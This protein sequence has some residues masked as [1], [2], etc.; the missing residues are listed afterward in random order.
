MSFVI[1]KAKYVVF[2][3]QNTYIRYLNS[4]SITTASSRKKKNA[5]WSIILKEIFKNIDSILFKP[6][7]LKYLNLYNEIFPFKIT[8]QKKRDQDAWGSIINCAKR[9]HHPLLAVSLICHRKVFK[10]LKGHGTGFVIWFLL[11]KIP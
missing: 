3:N 2:I 4:G 8:K 5:S 1:Q 10:F 11:T 7:F 6:Q 9:N